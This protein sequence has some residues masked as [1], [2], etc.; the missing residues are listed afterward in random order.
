VSSSR[1]N[2]QLMG[3][4][5][6]RVLTGGW[7]L[8]AALGTL[9]GCLLAT[10]L[11]LSPDMM[12][13]LLVYGFAAATIGGLN[14]LGGALV[15]G[16]FVGVAQTMLGGY[17]KLVSG[18][19]SL[20]TV[21]LLMV[22]M[23]AFRPGGLFGRSGPNAAIDDP[24]AID[25]TSGPVKPRWTIRRG[26]SAWRAMSGVGIGLGLLVAVAPAFIF[27]V[28]E[29]RLWT[30]VLATA[31]VLWGLSLLIGPAGQL[32]LGHGAFVGLGGYG[33]A[34]VVSR[35]GWPPYVG[36]ILALVVGF[37]VGCVL[38]LPALRIK[39]QY[40][41]MVTLS[42]AVVFPMVVARFTWFTGGSG[43]PR[44]GEAVRPPS[45]FPYPGEHPT[46]WLHLLIAL[47]AAAVL[48]ISLNVLRSPVGRAIRA[49]SQGDTA[50]L[51]MGVNVVRIRTATFGLAAA[52]AALGGALLAIHTRVVT[53]EQ[54]DLFRSLALYTA[55]VL[56][57]AES[58]AGGAIGAV[59]LVGVPW[60]NQ[61][62]GW[63]VS[64][65]LFYGLLILGVTAACP[66]GIVPTV[67]ARLR[68]VMQVVEVPPASAPTRPDGTAA[69][70]A[71][72]P[73]TAE[74][75]QPG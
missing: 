29:A 36:A 12:V 74:A 13:R 14:S 31:V 25:R 18:P 71:R 19:L 37:V 22:V 3:I 7:A 63:R 8:A 23:L 35:Y 66:D 30:E 28:L 5:T 69:I 45:W 51:A 43:G 67:R 47:V 64:P 49:T 72:G 44:V 6:G 62:F 65:N 2:S 1:L 17:I 53:T 40:L 58:L 54:F 33:T 10:R 60:L 27:P 34:I 16:L 48:I 4:R 57:G 11:I 26:S 52:F 70:G 55:V 42:F 50:A 59:L 61:K 24:L 32:S 21:L 9:A 46:T 41:A 15:G 75:A 56:G 39:G 38:G 20:P 68:R 73:A